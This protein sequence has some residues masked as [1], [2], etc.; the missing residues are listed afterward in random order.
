MLNICKHIFYGKK[1]A[2]PTRVQ[3]AGNIPM[4]IISSYKNMSPMSHICNAMYNYKYCPGEFLPR[5]ICPKR[6]CPSGGITLGLFCTRT[7]YP[8]TYFV[9]KIVFSS[10][11]ILL[12]QLFSGPLH[13]ATL[14]TGH[15][16][17]PAAV[18]E[19][20]PFKDVLLT[21]SHPSYMAIIAIPQ[22]KP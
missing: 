19:K 8:Y 16:S 22:A 12:W 13:M 20:E 1:Y 4:Q 21:S 7:L 15:C 5:G 18:F 9:L 11:S 17:Y 3:T 2:T 14:A 6:L 10:D